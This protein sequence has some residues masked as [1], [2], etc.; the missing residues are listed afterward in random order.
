MDTADKVRE[1]AAR[2][3]A[4]RLGLALRKSRARVFHLHDRGGYALIDANRN[5]VM[6]GPDMEMDLED[7][8]RRLEEY[9]AE[10]DGRVLRSRH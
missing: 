5:I 10:L 2:R 9:E 8:E 6:W 3:H 7:V 1:N 4:A